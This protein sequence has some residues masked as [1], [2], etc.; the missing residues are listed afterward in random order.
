VSQRIGV[1]LDEDL[2]EALGKV[3][4]GP[5]V[6][7]AFLTDE[8]E[9]QPWDSTYAVATPNRS[10]NVVLNMS[11][12]VHGYSQERT[13]GSSFMTFSP[14]NLA[15]QLM[16]QDDQ[17]I[18]KTYVDDLDQVLPGVAS[19]LVEAEV[20]RWPTASPYCFPGRGKLQSV[21]TRRDSRVMLA[22]DYLGTQYTETAVHSGLTAAQAAERVLETD[23]RQHGRLA[24]SPE[25]TA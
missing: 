1:D 3:E 25:P 22:G 12:N 7:A 13:P 21:L 17:T 19:H 14:G 2:R 5:F 16:E 15:R 23:R 10:F 6:S 20:A 4:Y 24:S 9:R 18:Q 8:T 11:N